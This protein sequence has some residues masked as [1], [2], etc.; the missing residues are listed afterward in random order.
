MLFNEFFALFGCWNKT[1]IGEE[2]FS[3][4][5][6]EVVKYITYGFW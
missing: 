3:V 4:F 1:S 5:G 6:N 2:L